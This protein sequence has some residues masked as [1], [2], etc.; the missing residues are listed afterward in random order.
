MMKLFQTLALLSLLLSCAFLAASPLSDEFEARI[1]Q[2]KAESEAL[3]IIREYL[4]R[5]TDL[6]DL[7]ILQN[8]WMRADKE[9]S[10]QY[11]SELHGKEP[12]S[13]VY[14]YLWLRGSENEYLQLAGGRDLIRESPEFYWG[15]RI[16]SSTYSQILLNEEASEAARESIRANQKADVSL[17][18]NS[19]KR[20]PN[21]AYLLLAL[22][23]HYNLEKDYATAESYLIQL[24]DPSA[25]R[26]NYKYVQE[27]IAASKRSRAFEVLYPPVLSAAI[28]KGE[29]PAADSLATYQQTYLQALTLAEEWP[30]MQAWLEANPSLKEQDETIGMRIAMH[31]GLEQYDTALN[32]LEGALAKDLV[33]VHEVLDEPGY[34]ALKSLP[35]WTEVIAN[36]HINWQQGRAARKE[37]ALAEKLSKPAPLWELPDKDGKLVKLE[38]QRGKIVILDFW[39][40][41][42]S[43]CLKTMPLLDS[44]LKKDP[45]DDLRVYSINTWESKASS[46]DVIDYM[47]KNGYAMTLLLGNNDIPKAYGFTGIPYICVLDKSGR[48]AYE[49]NGYTKDM[50]ELLDFWVEDLR[51]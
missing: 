20:F 29:L 16:F 2:T 42:C 40:T 15:Y 47:S 3:P 50:P 5:M 21:D 46:A 24:Q 4:P 31:I 6:E 9:A 30:K 36:A 22:F 25:I 43:P 19:L 1:R 12:K 37:K 48:I 49:L 35:R 51:K 23:H 26:M 28:A 44:W 38:D 10:Q 8:Y 27:F 33:D 34:E 11:F 17:L 39:A 45:S 14:H 32:L 13:P 7:R 41:W 18:K